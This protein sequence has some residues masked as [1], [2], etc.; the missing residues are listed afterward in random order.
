MYSYFESFRYTNLIIVF[1][2]WLIIDKVNDD[3]SKNVVL[4]CIDKLMPELTN[5]Y[6]ANECTAKNMRF[7]AL[8]K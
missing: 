6:S 3:T 8:N 1:R 7:K 5:K 4:S 2:K